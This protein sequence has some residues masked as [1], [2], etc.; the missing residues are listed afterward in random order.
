VHP[1]TIFALLLHY[2]IGILGPSR[3]VGSADCR[4]VVSLSTVRP[5]GVTS[6]DCYGHQGVVI[7]GGGVGKSVKLRFGAFFSILISSV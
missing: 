7:E 3:A 4:C 5:F 6:V 1:R 2:K